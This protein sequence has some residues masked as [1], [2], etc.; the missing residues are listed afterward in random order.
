MARAKILIVD[1]DADY[2]EVMHAALERAG[3]FVLEADNGRQALVLLDRWE[4]DLVLVDVNMPIMS[5]P[6]F[7]EELRRRGEARPF[8]IITISGSIHAHSSPT[9]W[10]LPKP[11]ELGL[12]LTLVENFCGRRELSAFWVQEQQR[13]SLTALAG[14]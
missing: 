13:E 10:F 3:Y 11:F 7:V 5:G 6:Q 14:I 12:L 2:R 8:G 1:D 9:E 4:A